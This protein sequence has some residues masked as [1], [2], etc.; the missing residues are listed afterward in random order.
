MVG[1][2]KKPLT[3]LPLPT[4]SPAVSWR[5]LDQDAGISLCQFHP[6]IELCDACDVGHIPTFPV[7]APLLI[8]LQT[9]SRL[10]KCVNAQ[11]NQQSV[12]PFG[13]SHNGN[14]FLFGQKN[15]FVHVSLI[16]GIR[17]GGPVVQID[18]KQLMDRHVRLASPYG[19]DQQEPHPRNGESLQRAAQFTEAC[20]VL[21]A[22]F[23]CLK[24]ILNAA[25]Y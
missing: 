21:R 9:S 15:T 7:P 20:D 6:C 5:R 1:E 18:L 4:R 25:L 22:A 2:H 16:E 19:S 24:H 8:N 23:Y 10:I 17:Q 3:T 13:Q 12:A 14:V 11:R